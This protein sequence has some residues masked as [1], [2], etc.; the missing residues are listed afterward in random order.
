[1]GSNNSKTTLRSNFKQSD[2]SSRIG[3]ALKAR[4]ATFG[5]NLSARSGSGNG[6]RTGRPAVEIQK[7]DIDLVHE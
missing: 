2:T 5:T 4:T 6:D 7:L 3:N 1:M